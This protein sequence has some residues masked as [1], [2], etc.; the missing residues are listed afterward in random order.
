MSSTTIGTQGGQKHNECSTA[1]CIKVKNIAKSV[2]D[3][4]AK[5]STVF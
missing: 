2:W 1:K 5:V 4:G 3:K